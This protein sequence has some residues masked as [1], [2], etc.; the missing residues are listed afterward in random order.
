[1]IAP[2]PTFSLTLPGGR[3]LELGR[4]TLV[5]GIL[6]VTPDSFAEAGPR[7]DPVAAVDAALE[8]EAEG[9]DLLDIGGEPSR[10]GADPVPATE[11][12][13]RVL[14]VIRGL[15][16]RLSIPVSIDTY[17]AR[18]AEAALGAGA[19]IVNDI[20]GLRYDAG[21]ARVVAG[22]G[23]ALV[24]MHTRGRSRTMYREAQ[25]AVVSQDVRAELAASLATAREAG[26][27]DDRLVLDLWDGPRPGEF[28][29]QT[30]LAAGVHNVVLEFRSTD[31]TARVQLDAA[32]PGSASRKEVKLF[33]KEWLR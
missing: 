27:S 20:S 7:T 4:R 30:T 19:A 29:A 8:M 17:K 11:E 18:V 3:R 33:R 15:A 25:Y 23:A 28:E 16:G 13:A 22:A 9:A 26:L 14:P 12:L 31:K 6:N 5:M 32:D 1:M 21:L 24:L 2:R 10:P